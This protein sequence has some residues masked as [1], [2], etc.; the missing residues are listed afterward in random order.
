ME[1]AEKVKANYN[2]S[3]NR[4]IRLSGLAKTRDSMHDLRK[5]LCGFDIATFN[6][7]I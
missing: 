5:M 7:D 3:K 2:S 4:I 6:S 1:A